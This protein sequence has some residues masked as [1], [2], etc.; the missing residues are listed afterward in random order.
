[1]TREERWELPLP[2]ESALVLAERLI[3]KA[4]SP[5]ETAV[6]AERAVLL[7]GP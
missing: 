5:N 1:V 7:A 6:H 4:S 3:G 2:D